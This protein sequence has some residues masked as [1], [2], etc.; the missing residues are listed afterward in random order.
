V[1]SSRRALKSA[2]ARVSVWSGLSRLLAARD[3]RISGGRRIVVLGYHRVAI[4]L[5]GPSATALESTCIAPETFRR[6]LEY[7]SPRFELV[8]M[9]QIVSALTG[10]SRPRRDLAAITFDDGYGDVLE[11]ALP[12]LSDFGATATI[13]VST[14]VVADRGFFP[15]DRLYALLQLIARRPDGAEHLDAKTRHLIHSATR[16]TEPRQLLSKL[17]QT[18]SH[19]Q[20]LELIDALEAQLGPSRPPEETRA[21]GWDGLGKLAD[22]GM[23][24][25]LHTSSHCVLPHLGDEAMRIEL[26]ESRRVLERTLQRHATHF[27]YCN[28]YWNPRSV[29]ALKSAGYTSAVTTEDRI[30]RVGDD[31]FTIGRRVLW[32]RSAYGPGDQTD[33]H[34][35]AC[36]LE[37]TWRALGLD[38]S[39]PGHIE[40]KI[41]ATSLGRRSA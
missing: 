35:L 12:I 8:G 32:E 18:Q 6:H 31:P 39:E 26:V 5:R 17:I 16:S 28:G 3:R 2:V 36:Q 9:T 7:L 25:G 30:N 40:P 33:A 19:G 14:G 22:A 37:G 4:P 41:E 34:L 20:L 21:M 29:Q 23:E 38:S 11:R 27:A 15:H 13:Y 1:S 10:R 24:I